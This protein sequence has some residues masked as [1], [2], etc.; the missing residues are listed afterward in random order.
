MVV[1]RHDGVDAVPFWQ[2]GNDAEPSV[3]VGRGDET[4]NEAETIRGRKVLGRG[5]IGDGSEICSR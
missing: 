5:R 3:L 4:M 1:K 2:V